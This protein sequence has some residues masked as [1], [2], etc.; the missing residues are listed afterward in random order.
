M[1]IRKKIKVMLTDWVDTAQTVGFLKPLVLLPLAL[2]NQLSVDQVETILLHEL[3][4]IRRH[5]Y[6]INMLMTLFHTI[7]FFNP[8]ARLFFKAVAQERE[9]ACD[10]GVLLRDYAPQVYAEALFALEKFR[11]L[12][13]S[14]SMAANGHN[15]RLLMNRIR[16][17]VGQPASNKNPFSP[18]FYFSLIAGLFIFTVSSVSQFPA[19]GEIIQ[20]KVRLAATGTTGYLAVSEKSSITEG[21][22]KKIPETV[23]TGRRFTESTV[24][25]LKLTKHSIKVRH[26][27]TEIK[28]KEP[29]LAMQSDEERANIQ[30]HFADRNE[31]RNYSFEKAADPT[32]PVGVDQ[33]SAPYVPLASFYYQSATDTVKPYL[34]LQDQL[35][36]LAGISKLKT[37]ELQAAL[38]EE[39]NSKLYGLRAMENENSILIQ[40]KQKNLK[41]LL[42]NLKKGIQLKKKEINHLRIQLQIQGGEVIVI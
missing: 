22:I 4:H 29:A 38:N 13:H 25:V 39:I 32:P 31:V 19:P 23:K 42:L 16:R 18:F 3:Q 33:E 24:L 9:H 17:V 27:K 11:Q 15:P 36:A 1:G 5:D 12:P 20:P 30:L 28:T 34:V 7:F 37:T 40:Q 26:Q 2:L 10:D 6:L 21:Q 14:F 41:P 35:N 8:F